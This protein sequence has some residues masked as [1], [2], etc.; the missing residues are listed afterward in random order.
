MV[1]RW[2]AMVQSLSL[3]AWNKCYHSLMHEIEPLH[4]RPVIFA[5]ELQTKHNT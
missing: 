2:H 3:N 5:V 1:Q 4:S